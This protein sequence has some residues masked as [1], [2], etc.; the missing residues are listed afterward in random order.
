MGTTWGGTKEHEMDTQQ[1]AAPRAP[2]PGRPPDSY[3]ARMENYAKQTASAV[4]TIAWIARILAALILVGAIIL[5]VQVSKMANE[6]GSGGTGTSACVSQGG[7]VP[8]C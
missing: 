1:F 8:G 6:L 3:E 5:A 4:K 2:L 7:T